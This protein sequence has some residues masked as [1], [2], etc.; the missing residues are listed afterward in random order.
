MLQMTRSQAH[1]TNAEGLYNID[2][3]GFPSEVRKCY[4]VVTP[5]GI[6]LRITVRM[7]YFGTKPEEVRSAPN[8]AFPVFHCSVSREELLPLERLN[9][10]FLAAKDGCRV[11]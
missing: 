8:E 4:V 3:L 2:D 6:L 5:E 7:E 1:H 10:V 9:S 11:A